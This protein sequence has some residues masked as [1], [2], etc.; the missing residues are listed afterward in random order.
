VNKL[1]IILFYHGSMTKIMKMAITGWWLPFLLVPWTGLSLVVVS[2]RRDAVLLLSFAPLIATGTTAT[3]PVD[4]AAATAQSSLSPEQGG[5][6]PVRRPYAPIEALVPAIRV[7]LQIEQSLAI[8]SQKKKSNDDDSIIMIAQLRTL[9]IVDDHPID[10]YFGGQQQP[11]MMTKKATSTLAT[12]NQKVNNNSN[13]INNNNAPGQTF[14]DRYE[15]NRHELTLLQQPGALLV[16]RGEIAAWQNLRQRERR[17]SQSQP[18]RAALNYYTD[19]LQFDSTKYRLTAAP[20]E[21]SR[22][23]RNDQLPDINQVVTSD[24]DLRYL[25]RNQVLTNMD[26]VVAELRRDDDECDLGEVV[27]LLEAATASM[28]QWLDLIDPNDVRAART[29][30]LQ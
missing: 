2:T 12:N 9:W 21:R 1:K 6:G 23:I 16:E 20:A 27:Q 26:D 7:A 24:L 14:L 29:L 15:R 17:Q 5:E 3:T 19:A 28:G 11:T 8:A 30:A 25:Y 18:A 13:I 22:M 10:D 4:D